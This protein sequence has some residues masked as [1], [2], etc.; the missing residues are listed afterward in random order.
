MQTSTKIISE[1]LFF[2]FNPKITVHLK[3]NMFS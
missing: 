2:V 3:E 1:V